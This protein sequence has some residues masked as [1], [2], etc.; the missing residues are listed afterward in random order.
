MGSVS[1]NMVLHDSKRVLELIEELKQEER[2]NDEYLVVK[3]NRTYKPGDR[4]VCLNQ[5]S[6][7][8][9]EVMLVHSVDAGWYAICTNSRIRGDIGQFWHHTPFKT[10]NT[11]LT[12]E[13]VNYILNGDC[14]WDENG[15]WMWDQSLNTITNRNIPLWLLGE[16]EAV[17]KYNH[18]DTCD[19]WLHSHF[20]NHCVFATEEAA[21]ETKHT[22]EKAKLSLD[23]SWRF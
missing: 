1:V 6:Y 5:T 15:E 3:Q 9:I 13:E 14:M 12:Q 19:S 18:W 4:F 10:K 7:C 16:K 11:Q 21:R 2:K 17:T 22:L 20:I 8:G 23:M